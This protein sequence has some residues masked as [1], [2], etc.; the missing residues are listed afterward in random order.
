MK[1]LVSQFIFLFLEILMNVIS[2]IILPKPS[3]F[4]RYY[5]RTLYKNYYGDK[6]EFDSSIV[7]ELSSPR[8]TSIAILVFGSF[9]C[10]SHFAKIIMYLKY[11]CNLGCHNGGKDKIYANIEFLN[12]PILII[13]LALSSS[14]VPKIDNE[15]RSTRFLGKLK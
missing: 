4:E 8:K 3:H 14:M 12:I 1:Y 15:I 9:Q 10:A 6:Y 2:L 7:N 11:L 13:N 5:L